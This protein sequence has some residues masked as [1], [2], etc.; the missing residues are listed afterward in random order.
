MRLRRSLVVALLAVPLVALGGSVTP[1][2]AAQ[3]PDPS[4]SPEPTPTVPDEAPQTFQVFEARDPFEQLVAAAN[5]GEGGGGTAEG[6]TSSTPPL[7]APPA[8][9]TPT[10]AA[11]GQAQ[12][13]TVELVDIYDDAGMPTA[14]VTVNGVGYD[15]QAGETFAGG[16]GMVEEIDPPC[17]TIIYRDN[18]MNLCEGEAVRK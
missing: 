18:R 10:P 11:T 9:A 16:D 7:S 14:Q 17:A 15:A 8:T 6:D 3:Q 4:P 13:A 1:R 12:G 5:A 2:V